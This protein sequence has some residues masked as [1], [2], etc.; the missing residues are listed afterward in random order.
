MTQHKKPME[1][2][3]LSLSPS[4][5]SAHAHTHKPHIYRCVLHTRRRNTRSRW[6]SSVSPSL[7]FPPAHTHTHTILI[8]IGVYSIRRRNT[9]SRWN[10]SVGH[11]GYSHRY[12]H[13]CVC[14]G[15]KER[16]STCV[17]SA[18]LIVF[19]S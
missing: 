12:I 19:V 16:A 14:E 6:N 8:Y 15:E 10:S 18:S 9:R 11:S 2:V 17:G 4:L 13:V 7:T 1:L 3:R 5:S